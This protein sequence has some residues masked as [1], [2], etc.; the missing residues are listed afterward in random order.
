MEKHIYPAV[1][2]PDKTV[3][4]YTVTFPDL[5]GCVTEGDTLSE[6]LFM[7]GDALGLYRSTLQEDKRPFPPAS[8][9]AGIKTEDNDFTT[10]TH[11]MGRG[12]R[13]A[14][15]RQSHRQES[16]DDSRSASSAAR[17]ASSALT[18]TPRTSRSTAPSSCAACTSC[19]SP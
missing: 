16:P 3:G 19:G 12:H 10:L 1:F 13:L 9:P 18:G 6:A 11:H 15:H 5:I 2:H 8:D 17:A 4:G 7:A 14:P